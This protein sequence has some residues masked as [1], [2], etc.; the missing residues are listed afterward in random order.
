M[1]RFFMFSSS[2][3]AFLIKVKANEAIESKNCNLSHKLVA[4][5]VLFVLPPITY[6][7]SP[8]AIAA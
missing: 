2:V 6:R 8:I 5:G 7:L 3:E 4:V 1:Y